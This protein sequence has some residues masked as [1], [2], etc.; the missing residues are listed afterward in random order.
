MEPLDDDEDPELL[1]S[2]P[3][4]AATVLPA[5]VHDPFLRL[6]RDDAALSP[7][8]YTTSAPGLS[9]TTSVV[10]VVTQSFTLF[11][12]ATYRSGYRAST[13]CAI[14]ALDPFAD[15]RWRADEELPAPTRSTTAQFMYISLLPILLNLRRVISVRVVCRNSPPPGGEGN[16]PCPR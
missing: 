11:R 15:A 12:F 3:E 10:S 16:L 5:P 6:M 1:A 4:D 7:S 13:A 14:A 8:P 2:D 9:N